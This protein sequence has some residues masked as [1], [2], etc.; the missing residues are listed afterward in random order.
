MSRLSIESTSISL[1]RVAIIAGCEQHIASAIARRFVQRGD[2]VVICGSPPGEGTTGIAGEFTP[3]YVVQDGPGQI[4][5]SALDLHGRL[6]VLVIGSAFVETGGAVGQAIE[7]LSNLMTT[8][9]RH[10]RS[11]GQIVNILSSAGRYR[12]AYFQSAADIDKSF[13][14]KAA[15]DGAVFALTRQ[16]GFE[17]APRVRVNAV[18]LGWIGSPERD[19]EWDA[20]S[21]DERHYLIEEISLSRLGEPDEVAAVVEFLASEA[22]S[23]VTCNAIDVNGGWWTS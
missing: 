1:E 9:A 10:M 23:Y 18:S 16:A 6:D 15:V 14:S 22:S 21:A 4:I 3:T 13:T 11:G 20:M 12:T 2:R 19:R 17:L 7:T 5:A 8:A